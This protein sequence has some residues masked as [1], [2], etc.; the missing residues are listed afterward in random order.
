[1]SEELSGLV[2]DLMNQSYSPSEIKTVLSKKGFLD[3]D[4][5]LMV[6]EIAGIS[7]SDK[8]KENKSLSKRLA[9]KE[10]FDRIGY[11]FVSHPFINILFSLTGASYFLIG[12]INGLRTVLSLLFSSFIREFSNVHIINKKFISRSGILYGFSFLV[13]SFAVVL[14]SPALY[15]LAFLFGS[16]G[17]VAHGELYSRFIKGHLKKEHMGS[18]LSK[19]GSYGMIIT[20]ISLL[21]SGYIM[22]LFPL[23]GKE[24]FLPFLGSVKI[25]GYL[26]SFEITAFAFIFSGLT[27]SYVKQKIVSDA[28]MY[29]FIGEFF[30][31]YRIHSKFFL[32]NKPVLLLVLTTI[33]TAVVQVLGNSFYGLF[34]YEHFKNQFLGG[35]LN[36]AII[37]SISAVISFI[38]PMF[39]K[40]LHKHIGISPMLVFGTL[41]SAMLPLSLAYNPNLVVVGISAALSIL[42]ASILG[43]AQGYF[44]HKLLSEEERRIYFSFIGVAAAIPILILTPI[45][46]ALASIYGLALLF[47]IIILM[48]VFVVA[49]LYFLIVVLYERSIEKTF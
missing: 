23:L 25:Y 31:R 34:I 27:M 49:P 13:M 32:H 1:M 17:I 7:K 20:I 28:K 44:S 4:I 42:G 37:F 35:F 16:L 48:L 46:A 22:E 30:T 40:I 45:G 24:M 14:R 21:L 8:C 33:I 12:L 11:G 39:T 38:G 36:V 9:L 18:F 6:E 41:L 15:A 3:S 10:I 5:D 47:K 2:K 43:M 19:I 26:I 29:S